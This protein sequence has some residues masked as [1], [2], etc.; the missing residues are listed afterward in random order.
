MKLIAV[1]SLCALALFVTACG[2]G[3]SDP[4]AA[5]KAA[6]RGEAGGGYP[7]EVRA[8]FMKS[9]EA[10]SGG[11]TKPCTRFLDCIEQRV[12]FDDFKRADAAIAKAEQ[13]P[14]SYRDALKPCTDA[15]TA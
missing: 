6:K 3:S 8:T 9:C 4:D 14:K 13:A 11:L 15:M 10:T 5:S 7:D 12:S 1:L 2:S